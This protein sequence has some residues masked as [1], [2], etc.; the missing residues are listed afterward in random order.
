MLS[1]ANA[2]SALLFSCLLA[3]IFVIASGCS[4]ARPAFTQTANA[5]EPAIKPVSYEGSSD[6]STITS[7]RWITTDTGLRYRVLKKGNGRK[8]TANNKVTVHYRGWLDN[9][10]E[11]DSSY[12]RNAPATFPLRGVVP[13]WREGLQYVEKGGAIE[14]EV[15]SVLGYGHRGSPPKIPGGATLHFYVELLDII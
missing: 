2:R 10:T 14:L 4:S 13:G 1:S 11:F 9:G 6:D 7:P 12:K 3:C 8:P 5:E 15:P